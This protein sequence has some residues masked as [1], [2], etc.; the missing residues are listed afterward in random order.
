M[1]LSFQT[2]I[3]QEY[4]YMTFS[5]QELLE[6]EKINIYFEDIKVK[7]SDGIIRTLHC[8]LLLK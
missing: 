1:L 7:L 5:K 3:A 8:L 6:A 4:K 2:I